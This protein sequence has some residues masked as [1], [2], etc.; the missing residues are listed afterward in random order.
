MPNWEGARI[1]SDVSLHGSGLEPNR[2][3]VYAFTRLMHSVDQ[4][5]QFT[6][7]YARY[8]EETPTTGRHLI[9]ELDTCEAPLSYQ[10]VRFPSSAIA[11]LKTVC[12]I[13]RAARH[14]HENH[15]E[16]AALIMDRV[17]SGPRVSHL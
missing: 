1:L 4:T 14:P 5:A 10:G 3:H 11:D 15:R 2:F 16:G 7:I 13:F 6:S 17:F 12:N 9:A 8:G